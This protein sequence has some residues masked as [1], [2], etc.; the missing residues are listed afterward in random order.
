MIKKKATSNHF[1][2]DFYLD[3]TQD[4]I[5]A[6]DKKVKCTISIKKNKMRALTSDVEMRNK[7]VENGEIGMELN[8]MGENKQ[9]DGLFIKFIFH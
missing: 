8:E 6:E 1:E 4:E 3:C 5:N 9:E 2:V 7:M